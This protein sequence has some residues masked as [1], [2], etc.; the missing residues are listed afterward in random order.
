MDF[1]SY[2]KNRLEKYNQKKLL[3]SGIIFASILIVAIIFFIIYIHKA[4]D[5]GV[6]AFD[7]SGAITNK[8]IEEEKERRA[9]YLEDPKIKEI[10]EK[11]IVNKDLSF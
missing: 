9:R 1:Y 10:Y 11:L 7:P 6:H 4:A 2:L 5:K 8:R 3:I